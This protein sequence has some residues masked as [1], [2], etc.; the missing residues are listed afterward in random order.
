MDRVVVRRD[1]YLD[2]VFLMATSAELGRLEGLASGQVLLATPANLALLGEQGFGGAELAGLGPTDLVVALRA[3]SPET[4]ERAQ[5]RL[6]ELLASKAPRGDDA[7]AARAVGLD[8]ALRELEG[9][10]MALISVPGDYAAYEAARALDAGLN[11]MLFSDN[12]P[13]EDEIALK[14][15]A[16]RRGLL[17]MG[18]DCGT[19]IVGGV[20]LGFANR[21]RRGPIGVVGASG[22][23]TQEVTCLVDRAGS[24]VS[25]AIGTGG[26][27]LSARVRARTT[28]FAVDLLARDPGTRVLV[29]VSKPP[30]ADVARLVLD[31]L[32]SIDKPSVVHFVGANR[33]ETRGHVV[34]T[35]DLESTALAAASLADGT[36]RPRGPGEARWASRL[37]EERARRAPGQRHLRGLFTGGTMAAEALAIASSRLGHVESNLGHD[38]GPM[39][40]APGATRGHL[41]VDLG[42]DQ[43]TRGRPHP[44]ID[45]TPRAQW[46]E[47]DAEDAAAGVVLLDVVLGTG[48][49]A[50]PAGAMIESIEHARA[51][52]AERGGYL[53]VVASVTGTPH[54]RQGLDRQ[55]ATLERAGVVVLP[56]NAQAA[57]FACALVEGQAHVV[58]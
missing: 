15:E 10:N 21:V 39:A 26:R 3:D 6:T 54:D 2:S 33:D 49:H 50:D 28:L 23:G 8:S 32:A 55:V 16:L 18:P 43:F 14:D 34:F 36:Q 52:A 41:V 11:V 35:P 13:V 19:A 47:A 17:L 5:R 53:P 22:T 37:A 24:G 9:A 25:H 29:V 40:A 46:L 12:V 1:C 45:P 42:D 30:A 51:R 57:R 20:M 27:D 31:R 44:M 38:E 56:S 7:G 58:G 4:L 48:S